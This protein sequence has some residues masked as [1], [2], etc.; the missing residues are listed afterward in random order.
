ML[1]RGPHNSVSQIA[2]P[3][4]LCDFIEVEYHKRIND[5]CSKIQLYLTAN[6]QIEELPL[7]TAELFHLLAGKLCDEL[8]SLFLKEAGIVFPYIRQQFKT[9]PQKNCI[10]IK[11]VDAIRVKQDIITMLLQK[12]RALL[13]NYTNQAGWSGG[14]KAAV[15]E[16]FNLEQLVLQW[17]HTEQNQLFPGCKAISEK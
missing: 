14:L 16:L 11:A 13:N 3:P 10:E 17:I 1:Q 7:S 6:P 8:H 12:L 15:E 9:F 4:E 5:S 2:T